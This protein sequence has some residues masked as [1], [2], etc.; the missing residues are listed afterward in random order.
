MKHDYGMCTGMPSKDIDAPALTK[1]LHEAIQ[2]RRLWRRKGRQVALTFE[3]L[4]GAGTGKEE[5]ERKIRL[6]MITT[7]LSMR[8]PHTLP[9]SKRGASFDLSRA[10]RFFPPR[11]GRASR[12]K[13]VRRT[14]TIVT[15]DWCRARW[16]CR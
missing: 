4:E 7:N 12:T 14:E 3:D 11:G 5:D 6:R 1:W 10:G 2:G 9:Y 13:S 15:R 16:T 8:R